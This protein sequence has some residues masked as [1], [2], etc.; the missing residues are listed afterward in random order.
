MYCRSI[1]NW[2][3]CEHEYIN[4]FIWDEVKPP[5]REYIEWIWPPNIQSWW[6][7]R[8]R[9]LSVGILGH[10]LPLYSESAPSTRVTSPPPLYPHAARLAIYCYL[11][12]AILPLSP[13]L[14]WASSEW[15]PETDPITRIYNPS[16]TIVFC[17]CFILLGCATM[18]L[19]PPSTTTSRMKMLHSY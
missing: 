7:F 13:S 18:E 12:S 2:K 8:P 14:R 16:V 4:A 17:F 19:P 1:F 5:T 11:Y 9:W 3:F 10:P 15:N 6:Y